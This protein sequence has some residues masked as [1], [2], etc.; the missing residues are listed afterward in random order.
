MATTPHGFNSSILLFKISKKFMGKA[1]G[2]LV[3]ELS[4]SE[5]R[6]IKN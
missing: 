6:I 5:V 3:S 4:K 1:A 2:N